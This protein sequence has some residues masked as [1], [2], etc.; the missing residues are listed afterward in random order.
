[1]SLSVVNADHHRPSLY[2]TGGLIVDPRVSQITD[3]GHQWQ[4]V[5][6]KA[7]RVFPVVSV[8]VQARDGHIVTHSGF[9]LVW[10]D[11]GSNASHA[12]FMDRT[13]LDFAGLS[14]VFRVGTHRR[15]TFFRNR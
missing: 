3:L 9:C 12:N 11:G 5:A 14:A 7:C 13:F 2:A 6:S 8:F 1:M 10:P 4:V 15:W